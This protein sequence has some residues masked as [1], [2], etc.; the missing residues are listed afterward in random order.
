MQ[1]LAVTVA[2]LVNAQTGVLAPQP[3]AA[4][5]AQAADLR[6]GVGPDQV[7]IG[8]YRLQQHKDGHYV[9]ETE[10]FVARIAEDGS[11]SF[12]DVPRLP[13]PLTAPIVAASQIVGAA[14]TGGWKA[15][16]K[17]AEAVATNPTLTVSEED[18]RK[19]THHAHKMTF[20]A[21]TAPFREGLRRT[22]DRAA[23]VGW[24]RRVNAIAGDRRV[25]AEQRR[26]TL[27]QLW[28][29]CEDSEAGDRARQA[30]EAAVR[31]HLPIG[32]RD[33]FTVK[34]L[35]RLNAGRAPGARF[36]PYRIS[37][38]QEQPGDQ[39]QPGAQEREQE[40]QHR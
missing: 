25:P 31:Q 11:V 2:L 5:P 6:A 36:Q 20:L 7:K 10:S 16:R 37:R 17:V 27:F 18:V 3:Q 13:G 9:V 26:Q 32:S 23:L 28:L 22:R 29:E 24:G 12:R 34:E 30:I 35:Q 15:T 39:Q 33:A 4:Q 38:E 40:Q 8:R 19:D 21:E 1:S 14:T